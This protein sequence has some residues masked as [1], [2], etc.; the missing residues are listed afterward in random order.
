MF[1]CLNKNTAPL[2]IVKTP[3]QHIEDF[4]ELYTLGSISFSVFEHFRRCDPVDTHHQQ[5]VDDKIKKH[6]RSIYYYVSIKWVCKIHS[7]CNI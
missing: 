6:D 4:L 3:E 2:F 7:A 5:S 1:K